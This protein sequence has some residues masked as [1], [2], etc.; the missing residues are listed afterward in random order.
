M[1]SCSDKPKH[2]GVTICTKN[3]SVYIDS[4]Y[5]AHLSVQNK[6]DISPNFYIVKDKDT[7][8]LPI[9]DDSQY[10]IF[11]AEGSTKGKKTYKGYVEYVNNNNEKEKDSFNIVFYVK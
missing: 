11:S 2:Q 7:F 10:A 3:D 6:K 4:I 1:I 9:A 8:L 5:E